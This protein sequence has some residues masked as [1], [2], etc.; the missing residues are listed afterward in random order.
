MLELASV[1]GTATDVSKDALDVARLNAQSH[2]CDKRI[3]F[4]YGSMLEPARGP[5]DLVVSNPPY[6]SRDELATLGPEVKDYDPHL[7][8]D[9]GADGLDAYRALIP[10]AFAKLRDGGFLCVEIG[11]GQGDQVFDLMRDAGFMESHDVVSRRTDLAGV[12][13]VVTGLKPVC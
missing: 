13:R 5:F 9:G 12:E 7:A 3:R 10:Q 8:L 4:C 2:G 11:M 6:I 1:E